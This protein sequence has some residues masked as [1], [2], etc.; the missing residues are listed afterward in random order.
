VRIV[1]IVRIWRVAAQI[2]PDE[3][4]RVRVHVA[5]GARAIGPA[6]ARQ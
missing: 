3:E 1:R 4:G 2:V 5:H 6:R